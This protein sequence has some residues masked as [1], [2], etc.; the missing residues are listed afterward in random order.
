MCTAVAI[1]SG[2]VIFFFCI[3]INIRATFAQEPEEAIFKLT[4]NEWML[5]DVR[6][7]SLDTLVWI[8]LSD[9]AE[10]LGYDY[11]VEPEKFMFNT[12]LPVAGNCFTFRRDTLSFQNRNTVC[13]NQLVWIDGAPYADNR[14]LHDLTGIKIEV[15]YRGLVVI[16]HSDILFPVI[17]RQQQ[18]EKRR[19]IR[20]VTIRKTVVDSFPSSLF[21]LSSVGYNAAFYTP[22]TQGV[23]SVN[24]GG[25]LTGIVCGGALRVLYNYSSLASKDDKHY[26]TFLWDYQN[27][28]LG[29][30]RQA[31]LFRRY[32]GFIMHTSG[33]ANGVYFSNEVLGQVET[34]R[35]RLDA[36]ALPGQGVEIR[37]NGKFID[38]VQAD[39]NGR[40]TCDVPMT[41]GDNQLLTTAYDKF[42]IPFSVEK[43]VRLYPDMQPDKK[44]SYKASAG[45]VDD[46]NKF[47]TSQWYYG[48]TNFLTLRA[49][50]EILW[51]HRFQT[52]FTVGGSYVP[53]KD[54]RINAEYIP[55]V[56]WNTSVNMG[57]KNKIHSTLFYEHYQKNQ[58][59]VLYAP[60]S[61]LSFDLNAELPLAG[62]RSLLNVGMQYYEYP[63]M[64]SFN[65]N[66]RQ[67]FYFRQLTAGWFLSSVSQR[68]LTAE[69]WTCGVRA[70]YYLRNG[71]N[72]ELTY[73][74]S[75]FPWQSRLRNRIN[76]QKG[77]TLSFYTDT[78]YEFY[79]RGYFFSLGITWNLPSVRLRSS[80]NVSRHSASVGNEIA[81]SILL[82]GKGRYLFA[83]N[84]GGSSLCVVVFLDDNGNGEYDRGEQVMR[85]AD[86]F[87]HATAETVR[88]NRGIF[89]LNLPGET[90]FRVVIPSQHFK[91][92]DW[93]VKP[94]E[95]MLVLREF[96]EEVI[97]VPVHVLSEVSGQIAS[98]TTPLSGVPVE[99]TNLSTGRKQTIISDLWG[100]FTSSSITCGKY[101]VRIS[102]DYLSAKQL[103]VT[104]QLISEFEVA[105]GKEGYQ[106]DGLDFVLE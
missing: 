106:I 75:T 105:A 10:R 60:Q 6:V 103:K 14:L 63:F 93:Q 79:H 76:Y 18:E 26:S 97:F 46:G 37:N 65:L 77:R 71:W 90:P 66:F 61:R 88:N 101:S 96:Q 29:W 69:R 104:K 39:S 91:D 2:L 64:Q 54:F 51:D 82:F 41:A 40:Y 72:T 38:Y 86:V 102:P 33:Y 28:R 98:G 35:Y 52:L 100:F 87:V 23:N 42:A 99:L 80:A 59:K 12:C 48:L 89:F 31:S 5:G 1:R 49:G 17:L 70:G 67:N 27:F 50:N 16:L 30:V 20:S 74:Y 45:W 92:I 83:N 21:R 3:C 24:A 47:L 95:K 94:Y 13:A 19:L 56:R 57:Y 11:S 8:S 9:L 4:A 53:G 25:N 36:V 22:L 32:S 81:G 15:N 73:E 84:N 68:F 55:T 43:A 58:T 34:R 44:L 85:D 62:L 7:V 78:D